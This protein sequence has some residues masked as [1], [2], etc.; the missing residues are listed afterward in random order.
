MKDIYKLTNM[1]CPICGTIMKQEKNREWIFMLLLFLL[2]LL[3]FAMP[4]FISYKLLKNKIF[5][6]E[7]PLVGEP[8][9]KTCAMCGANVQIDE[10]IPYD[11]LDFKNKKIYDFR[12][13][14]RI[15]YFFG[16][17]L[18]YCIAFGFFIFSSHPE[19][20]QIATIFLCLIPI[21]LIV[22]IYL[23]YR[24]NIIKEQKNK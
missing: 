15:S 14:F 18:L 20:K 8:N 1:R 7:I 6:V 16:G 12:W 21:C 3:I 11:K 4:F 24:W 22:I 5:K 17:V 9:I 23:I 19:D 13:N 2:P 10:K